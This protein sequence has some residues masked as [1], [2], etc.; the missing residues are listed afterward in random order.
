MYLLYLSY[1][2]VNLDFSYFLKE[3]I[4]FIT[5]FIL[6]IFPWFSRNWLTIITSTINAWNWGVNYQDG[7]EFYQ[8]KSWIYY[9]KKLPLIFGPINFSIFTI[10]LLIE[11]GLERN[12]FNFKIKFLNKLNLWFLIYIFNCYLIISLMSTKDIRFIM[13]I[14]PIL[15]IYPAIFLD[16]KDF[17]IFSHKSKKIILIISLFCSLFFTKNK[18][19]SN[20]LNKNSIYNWPH[21]DIIKEIKKKVKISHQP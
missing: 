20:N 16:S 12:L 10:I 21:A 4:F 5:F 13:P 18:L 8:I 6:I 11:K 15:C 9:F 1:L 17:K 2:N 19:Y 7:L 3:F 14:F